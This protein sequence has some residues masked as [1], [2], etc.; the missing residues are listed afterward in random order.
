MDRCLCTDPVSP[1]D[2]YFLLDST[3]SNEMEW[4]RS[5]TSVPLSFLLQCS[6][7]NMNMNGNLFVLQ[8][9]D[10]VTNMLSNPSMEE[11]S[12]FE[13]HGYGRYSSFCATL[14]FL[15]NHALSH[16]DGHHPLLLVLITGYIP[17]DTNKAQRCDVDV[18][19]NMNMN[20]NVSSFGVYLHGVDGSIYEHMLSYHDAFQVSA[21]SDLQQ[22]ITNNLVVAAICEHACDVSMEGDTSWY[23]SSYKGRWSNAKK[24]KKDNEDYGY[25]G[26]GWNARYKT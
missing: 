6:P 9:T 18:D 14:Q 17:D 25:H 13:P 19:V 11:L 16:N 12:S 10:N 23:T 26:Q 5:M 24:E 7:S 2:V 22:T 3:N 15:Q 20:M 4:H 21:A 8:Y 1:I